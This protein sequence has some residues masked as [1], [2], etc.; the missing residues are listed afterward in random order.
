MR[1]PLLLLASTEAGSGCSGKTLSLPLDKESLVELNHE[2]KMV[3]RTSDLCGP[4]RASN[5]GFRNKSVTHNNMTVV[6]LSF[7]ARI[8]LAL[9]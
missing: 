1:L 6:G 2:S 9:R 8:R 4:I 3:I 7:S 5:L